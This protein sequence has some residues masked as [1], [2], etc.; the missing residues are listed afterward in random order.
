MLFLL[1][2]ISIFRWK[3]NNTSTKVDIIGTISNLH[4]KIFQIPKIFG[5]I[6]DISTVRTIILFETMLAYFRRNPGKICNG[7]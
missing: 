1:T 3:Y 5:H 6:P 4:K 2:Y 7:S